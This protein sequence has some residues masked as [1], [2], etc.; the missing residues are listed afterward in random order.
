M[1]GVRPTPSLCPCLGRPAPRGTDHPA[2]RRTGPR[3]YVA[4]CSLCFVGERAWGPSDRRVPA[5]PFCASWLAAQESISSWP[6]SPSCQRTMFE[7]RCSVCRQ[8]SERRQPRYLRTSRI[9]QPMKN[10]SS[11][12]VAGSVR[13]TVFGSALLGRVIPNTRWTATALSLWRNSS[14]WL[15]WTASV[16]SVCRR[17]RAANKSA[18]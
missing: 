14:D 11:T 13:L 5:A 10:L 2:L 7:P 1:Q 8:S 12:G 17:G 18:S 16:L 6:K 9:S 4:L 3:R 15:K